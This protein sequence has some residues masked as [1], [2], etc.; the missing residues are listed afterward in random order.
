[1]AAARSH[2]ALCLLPVAGT[3]GVLAKHGLRCA[4]SETQRDSSSSSKSTTL[5][6]CFYEILTTNSRP[7]M[8]SFPVARSRL[9]HEAKVRRT[10]DLEWGNGGM[11]TNTTRGEVEKRGAGR[12]RKGNRYRYRCASAV[13]RDGTTPTLFCQNTFYVAGAREPH[14]ESAERGPFPMPVRKTV[15][16]SSFSYCSGPTSTKNKVKSSRGGRRL[17]GS[18]G[19][20]LAVPLPW[21]FHT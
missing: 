11:G 3:W 4:P 16:L 17:P 1:M 12:R 2:G 5:L 21:S 9:G 8:V 13:R 15:T 7:K 10:L 20:P 19:V 18:C 14:A 6:P